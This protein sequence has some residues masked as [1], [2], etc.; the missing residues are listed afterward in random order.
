MS[1]QPVPSRENHRDSR[2][3]KVEPKIGTAK[4]RAGKFSTEFSTANGQRH[5]NFLTLSSTPKIQIPR[6][7][8]KHLFAPFHNLDTHRWLSHS[9]S[10]PLHHSTFIIQH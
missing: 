8:V 6:Y 1:R 3:A 9:L 10:L 5:P 4:P 7:V 2:A